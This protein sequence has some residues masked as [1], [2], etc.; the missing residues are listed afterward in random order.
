MAV[1]SGYSVDLSTL[2]NLNLGGQKLN[3][4]EAIKMWRQTGSF[5]NGRD[6]VTLQQGMRRPI[7]PLMGG[8][9]VIN[10]ALLAMEAAS[11][12]IE[13]TTGINPITIGGTPSD[14]Q[15][16]AVTQFAVEGTND[17]LSGI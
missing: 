14:R 9:T 3:P 16:K 8:R 10:D 13:D 17:V 4:L 15:G 11:K 1:L 2:N 5:H 6:S 12:M 7:E